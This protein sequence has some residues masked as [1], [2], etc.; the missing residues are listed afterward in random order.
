MSQFCSHC[1]LDLAGFSDRLL[2]RPADARSDIF[3]LGIILYEIATGHHPWVSQSNVDTMHAILHAELAPSGSLSPALERIVRRCLAKQPEQRHQTMAELGAAMRETAAETASHPEGGQRFEELAQTGLRRETVSAPS[4][5]ARRTLWASIAILPFANMSADKENE[6][7]GDGLA[8]EVINALA[9]APG[10]RVAGRTS[11]FFFRG[12]DLEFGEIGRRLNV[13]HIL[14][15]SIRRAG[16]RVR[17]TAQLIKVGDGF[18]LWSERYDRELTDIFAIQ[19]EITAAIAEALRVRLAPQ[20]AAAP[21][22]VPNLRAYDAFLEGREHLLVRPAGSSYARGKELLERAMELDPK[23][24]LPHSIMGAYYTAQAGRGSIAP[25]Q[26]IQLARAAEEAALGIDP[27]LPEA[28]GMLGVLAG[29]DYNW[30]EAEA[31]WRAAMAREPAP[32][33]VLF[34]YGNHY[35]LPIGR[36]SQAVELEFRVLESDPLNLLYRMLY[37]IAL[38]HAGRLQDAEAELQKVME[39]DENSLAVGTLGLIYARQGRY[40][41]ALT[42]TERAHALAPQSDLIMG[43]LA[44]LLVRSGAASRAKTL[45]EQVKSGQSYT[46]PVGATVFHALCGEFDQAAVWAERAIEERHPLLIARLGPL[47]RQSAQWPGLARQ[48]NLP[49]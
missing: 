27:S 36:S 29:M 15:G 8:E 42:A 5:D 11:S 43:Q 10:L 13:T 25:R 21:R 17:V 34:W 33:D 30:T 12:K 14:E 35:L 18:H 7:F 31:H 46:A 39:L 26:A 37:A 2:G 19:D 1:S 48:M 23:F 16:N 22:H 40:E 9:Q 45:I 32:P 6:Y 28:R 3:A 20:S 44:A 49:A 38:E 24:A 4:G 47:M 41:E